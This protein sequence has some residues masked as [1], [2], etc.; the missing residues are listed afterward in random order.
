MSSS[1]FSIMLKATNQ[2]FDPLFVQNMINEMTLLRRDP[3]GYISIIQSYAQMYPSRYSQA[4]INETISYLSNQQP[5][6]ATYSLDRTL[7]MIAQQWVDSQG[8]IGGMGHGNFSGRVQPYGEYR[9]IAENI[10][11]GLVLPRDIIV[12]WVVD[13][14][15]PDRGHRLNL[16][17]CTN[18]QL[19]IATGKHERYRNMVSIIYANGFTSYR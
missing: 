13:A 16:F 2:T 9:S 6:L 11:Y 4:D 17:K 3:R 7:T 18:N 12:A 15:I 14:G 8:P 1:S 10:A 19:G 5:C